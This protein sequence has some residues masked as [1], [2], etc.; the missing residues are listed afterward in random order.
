MYFI[1]LTIIISLAAGFC[2][3]KR[4]TIKTPQSSSVNTFAVLAAIGLIIRIAAAALYYGHRT[5]VTD[6]L[7]WSDMVFKDGI[8]AFYL[9]DSFTDYP[10]G[11][12]YVLWVIGLLRNTFPMPETLEL[13]LVKLPAIIAD[14]LISII[15]FS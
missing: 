15:L 11:Y 3:A 4:T 14:L 1:I 2:L 9:S 13:I 7:A 10:P 5:D 6:F 8:P 12:M